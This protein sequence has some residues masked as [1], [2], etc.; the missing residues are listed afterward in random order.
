MLIYLS[1]V[2][3]T[4]F[5]QRPHHMWRYL[6]ERMPADQPTIWIE[7]Y[8]VRSPQ[9]SDWRRLFAKLRDLSRTRVDPHRSQSKARGQTIRLIAL[10]GESYFLIRQLNRCLFAWQLRKLVSGLKKAST[11]TLLVGKPSALSLWLADI[12]TFDRVV[13][14]VMDNFAQFYSGRSRRYLEEVENCLVGRADE[15]L[16]SSSA[17]LKKIP[18]G[19]LLRNGCD[20]AKYAGAPSTSDAARVLK[21]VYIGVIAQW[22]DWDWLS[23]LANSNPDDTVHMHGPIHGT[24]PAQLPSN[25]KFYGELDYR[26]VPG[27]LHRT[28]IGIIPFLK[29]G[30][31]EHV[32]PIK[33]YEYR[34]AGCWVIS[35]EFGDINADRED[36]RLAI[37]GPESDFQNFSERFPRNDDWDEE[38]FQANIDWESRFS[39]SMIVTNLTCN[40]S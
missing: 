30:L 37:L 15:I 4:S 6:T 22:I 36:P 39:S 14:D 11:N 34:A 3:S 31:T 32:D 2:A 38:A 7:P 23:R 21:F 1:P 13:F 35:S 19:E 10:P 20:T 18:G 16:V 8:P 9:V 33:Y 17:L 24:L 28:K 25:L 27:L 5:N 12:E 26:K 40:S 29:T